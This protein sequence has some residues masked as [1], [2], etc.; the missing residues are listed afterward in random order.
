MRACKILHGKHWEKENVQL[1]KPFEELSTEASQRQAYKE[2]FG[3][4]VENTHQRQDGM[5]ADFCDGQVFK[6]HPLFSRDPHALQIILYY[7]EVE[8]VNPL[9]S[10][11]SK[12]KV[13]ILIQNSNSNSILK[14]IQL[15]AVAKRPVIQKYG[16]NEILR[17]LMMQ[18]DELEQDGGCQLIINGRKRSFSG[19]LIFV[20]GDNL[21]SQE[22]GGFKIGGAASFKCRVC[23]GNAIEV[24]S[25]FKEDDFQ[26]RTR[27]M[28]NQ[29]CIEIENAEED[30]TQQYGINQRSIPNLSRYFH[31]VGGLP[32]DAMH[33]VLEGLLQYE[34][35]EF[36][37]Y[38]MYEKRFLTL[39]NLKTSIR[40]FDYGYPDAANKP[41]LIS[42]KKLNSG[43]NSLK[44]R[45][46]QMWCLGRFLPLMI[47][48]RIP[49]D[50]EKWQLFIILLEI[51]S[52]IFAEM[53][54]ILHYPLT[55]VRA[56]WC[57]VNRTKYKKC[58]AVYIGGDGL[59][60]KFATIEEIVTV[61]AK[62]NTICF[63]LKQLETLSYDNHTHSYRVRGDVEVKRQTDLVT[64][65]PLHIVTMDN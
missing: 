2:L 29:N 38:A 11:T 22:I 15:L 23:M 4:V 20:S 24:A 27:E 17:T 60:P 34:V 37:K 39:D 52:I 32:G 62:E 46:S 3:L 41:S 9:G 25:K 59:L 12:H 6:E 8:V 7:D 63:V 40:D 50:D 5:I 54:Y 35:K 14:A 33:D 48:S 58:V 21:A 47:G 57:I 64:F 18:I 13:G 53:H 30:I 10:K 45:A 31:V 42:S 16:C 65:R 51:V 43:T 26:L 61:P 19:T 28:Y 55:M 36:L 44:Q 56:N 49:G 1:A